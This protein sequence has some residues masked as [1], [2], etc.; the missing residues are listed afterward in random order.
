[1]SYQEYA[2]NL[3]PEARPNC[4]GNDR[5]YD[6]S[7]PDCVE[8]RY[9]H[10]CTAQIER[11]RRSETSV[12][13]TRREATS[14]YVRRQTSGRIDE[15]LVP[16]Y[17]CGIVEESES[18]WQRFIKDAAGGAARGSLLAGYEFWCNYRIK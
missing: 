3:A 7:D 2:R 14:G 15:R 5:N 1:M 13:P 6:S 17:E 4:W 8:C 9:K 10:S 18:P 16:R 11:N 12:V